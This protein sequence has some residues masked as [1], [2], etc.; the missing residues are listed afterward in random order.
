MLHLS[1]S[2]LGNVLM[3]EYLKD[4]TNAKLVMRMLLLQN[5]IGNLSGMVKHFVR[6]TTDM[7]EG[8]THQ[9]YKAYLESE[10][11]DV[12]MQ[13]RLFTEEL[14]FNVTD[15]RQMGWS[16]YHERKAE[17]EAKGHGEEFI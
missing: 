16:R 17:F 10:L 11:A 9:A 8:K 4:P 15:A 5:Q 12:W 7:D 6:G 3:F 13:L 1:R 2:M 14:G